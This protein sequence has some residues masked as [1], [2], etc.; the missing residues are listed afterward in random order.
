MKK[1]II[2]G[3]CAG[4]CILLY[5]LIYNR[6][7]NK[8]SNSLL[9][10]I[11]F[12]FTLPNILHISYINYLSFSLSLLLITFPYSLSLLSI[13]LFLS[14]L[15]INNLTVAL[16]PLSINH[17]SL[18]SFSNTHIS[19]LISDISLNKYSLDKQHVYFE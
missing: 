14:F 17:I 10:N 7:L 6:K 9:A 4:L 2:H 13:S 3:V 12:S 5:I 15:S 18:P 8:N 1:Y 19:P 16:S 11:Y